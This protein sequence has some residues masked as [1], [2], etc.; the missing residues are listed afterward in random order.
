MSPS[1]RALSAFAAATMALAAAGVAQQS[2]FAADGVRQAGPGPFQPR[3]YTVTD[4]V[5]DSRD[6]LVFMHSFG[7]FSW[8]PVTR[9]ETLL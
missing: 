9:V 3:G 6:E 4:V 1:P 7:L 8:D 2:Q 5:G